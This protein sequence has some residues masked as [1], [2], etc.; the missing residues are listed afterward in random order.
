MDKFN[1]P[2]GLSKK[3]TVTRKCSKD[4]FNNLKTYDSYISN[5]IDPSTRSLGFCTSSATSD[6]GSLVSTIN[7]TDL[8]S[9]TSRSAT[10]AMS[11][12]AKSAVS[13]IDASVDAAFD[14]AEGLGSTVD[15]ASGGLKGARGIYDPFGDPAP[16]T[17]LPPPPKPSITTTDFSNDIQ[18][19]K[20]G[21]GG[22][23]DI[24][25]LPPTDLPEPPAPPVTTTNP[26]PPTEAPCPPLPPITTTEPCITDGPQK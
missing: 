12:S 3:F 24:D 7:S 1:L 5:G 19:E 21:G 25:P 26:L 9:Y 14:S 2:G 23:E 20:P 15:A 22:K 16:P 10:S 8:Y 18:P 4:A 17:D 6:S 11:E 13:S